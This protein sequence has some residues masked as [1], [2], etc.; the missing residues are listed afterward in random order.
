M[1]E[2]NEDVMMSSGRHVTAELTL[3]WL[4]SYVLKAAYPQ[5]Q[6]DTQYRIA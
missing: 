3:L 2:G 6:E 4:K 5:I 1:V